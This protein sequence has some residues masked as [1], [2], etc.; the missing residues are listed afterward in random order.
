MMVNLTPF[1]HQIED[2]G[3]VPSI[4]SSYSAGTKRCG[5]C[6]EERE[7]IVSVWVKIRVDFVQVIR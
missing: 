2:I 7:S 3:G 6:M 4:Q 5:I 1:R